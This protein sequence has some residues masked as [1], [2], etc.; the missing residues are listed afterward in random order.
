MLYG[1]PSDLTGAKHLLWMQYLAHK[2]ALKKAKICANF[3]VFDDE[4]MKQKAIDCKKL[5]VIHDKAK[6]KI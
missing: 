6:F 4:N 1:L 3:M 5:E 2:I